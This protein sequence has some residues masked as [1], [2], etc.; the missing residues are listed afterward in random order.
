MTR[1]KGS[2]AQVTRLAHGWLWSSL[3]ALFVL[4]SQS[5]A[6]DVEIRD[7]KIKID[8]KAAGSYRMS[9]F[10][11]KEGKAVMTGDASVDVRIYL[12]RYT[13]SYIGTETWRGNRL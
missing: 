3:L 9:I 10:E 8:G 12:I 1:L 2:F 11:G 6:A 4:V 5:A 13:Y 7:F